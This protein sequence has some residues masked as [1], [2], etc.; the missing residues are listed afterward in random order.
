MRWKG[1]L[2]LS[3]MAIS[4]LVESLCWGRNIALTSLGVTAPAGSDT[5]VHDAYVR[6]PAM[7]PLSVPFATGLI[8]ALQAAR[9][10]RAI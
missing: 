1:W 8:L 5:M 2:G 7:V 10:R 4:A 6:F 3:L 9:E